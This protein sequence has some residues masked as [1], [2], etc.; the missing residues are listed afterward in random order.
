MKIKA[1]MASLVI[2]LMLAGSAIAQYSEEAPY[3]GESE[4]VKEHM[5]E[6]HQKSEDAISNK[7]MTEVEALR[8]QVDEL[9]ALIL[10]LIGEE[11]LND[12]GS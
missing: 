7:T 4:A 8:M 5:K 3:S 6:I 10:T 1:L 9:E 2:S 12:T 11:E